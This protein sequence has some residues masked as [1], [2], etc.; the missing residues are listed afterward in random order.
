VRSFLENAPPAAPPAP[1]ETA[2]PIKSE[3]CFSERSS[4]VLPSVTG[5][6]TDFSVDDDAGT[7]GPDFFTAAVGFPRAAAFAANVEPDAAPGFTLVPPFGA[8]AGFGDAGFVAL[9][10]TGFAGDF[11]SAGFAAGFFC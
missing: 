6:V 1:T 3:I 2:A 4:S 7:P 8:P 5:G 9:E 11:F 10:A